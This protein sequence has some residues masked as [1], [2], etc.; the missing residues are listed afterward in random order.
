MAFAATITGPDKDRS[1]SIV[2]NDTTLR[3]GEQ[4]PGMPFATPEN[5]SI[6]RAAGRGRSHGDRGRHAGDGSGRDCRDPSGRRSESCGHDHRLVPD[7][8]RGRR[9]GDRG[10]CFDGNPI[11]SIVRR[12]DCGETRWRRLGLERVQRVVAQA[13]EKGLGGEDSSRAGVDF[14]IDLIASAK[15]VGARRFRIADT[16]SVLYPDASFALMAALR[17]STDLEFEFHGQDDLGLATADTLAAI[18][19]GA[20]HASVTVIGLGERAGN[21]R[22]RKLPS[23]SAS[24]TAVIPA[25]CSPNWSCSRSRGVPHHSAQQ[26]M[27]RAVLP[28]KT[29]IHVDGLLKDRATYQARDPGLLRRSHRIVLASI[30]SLRLSLRCC[31]SCSFRSPPT[32]PKPF[33]RASVSMPSSTKARFPRKRWWRS[34]DIH[35]SSPVS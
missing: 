28:I 3:D 15:A 8:A 11:D 21:V 29:G 30:Q 5:V 2:L 10:G 35:E 17:A 18:K 20:T 31:P 4:T 16:L 13:R 27:S 6:A 24:S 33:S 32:K 23:H 22:W 7:K 19:A 9:C 12:A 34:G 1:R 25:C 14:L 26:A